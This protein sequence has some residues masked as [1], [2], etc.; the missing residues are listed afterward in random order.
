MIF[1]SDKIKNSPD[2]LYTS[3]KML[4]TIQQRGDGIGRTFSIHN[5]H[6]R[7][8]Q[9]TGNLGTASLHPVITVKKPHHAFGHCHIRSGRIAGI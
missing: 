9:H 8:L 1:R 7:Y 5:Q 3:I 2:H 4:E 6:N